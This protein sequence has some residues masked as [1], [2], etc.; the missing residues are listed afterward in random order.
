M[1]FAIASGVE[2]SRG[3]WT[4]IIAGFVISAFGGSLVQVG[5]PTGAFVPILF[6]IVAKYG[7]DGLVVA[8]IMAGHLLQGRGVL[9][10]HPPHQY[11]PP[12]HPHGPPTRNYPDLL[13]PDPQSFLRKARHLP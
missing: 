2:P 5:G 12:P 3:L 9:Q 6:A 8:T 10:H 13:L 7:Y 1:G 11:H 4:A